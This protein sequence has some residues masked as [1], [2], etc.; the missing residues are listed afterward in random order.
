MKLKPITKRSAHGYIQ[1]IL[2]ILMY[3]VKTSYKFSHSPNCHWYLVEI[4][5]D[6]IFLRLV[7][8]VTVE[9]CGTLGLI[10]T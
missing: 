10:E 5:D 8:S 2:N 1:V 3:R 4:M 6:N 9:D 7:S